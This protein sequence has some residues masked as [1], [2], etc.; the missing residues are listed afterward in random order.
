MSGITAEINV[1]QIPRSFHNILSTNN[2]YTIKFFTYIN[3][4]YHETYDFFFTL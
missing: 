4:D 3:Q 2:S 1:I